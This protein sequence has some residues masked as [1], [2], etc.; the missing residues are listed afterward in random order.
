MIWVKDIAN[1]DETR[2]KQDAERNAVNDTS[3]D[4]IIALD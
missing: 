3:F 4:Q 2:R 1:Y